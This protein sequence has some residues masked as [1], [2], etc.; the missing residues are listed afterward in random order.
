MSKLTF[1]LVGLPHLQTHSS[2]SH[3][4]YS[5]KVRRFADMMFDRGHQ[6]YLYTSDDND[7]RC[8]EHISCISKEQQAEL[9]TPP[10]VWDWRTPLW[11]TMA[12]N[13]IREIGKR[14]QP[15]DFLCFIAG[16]QK[17]I[18]EAFPDM[19]SVEFGVGYAG[20]FA[21]FV[22]YESYAWMHAVYGSQAGGSV[23]AR[24]GKNFDAVIP[25]AYD[26]DEFPLGK[27]DGGYLLYM[28]RLIHLKGIDIVSAIQKE[29]GLPLV[30]AGEGDKRP[31]VPHEY[32][33]VVGPEK[34]AE[35]MG[36]AIATLYP[37]MYLEPF[38]GVAVETMFTGTPSITSDW[39][40][41]PELIPDQYRARTL[42]EYLDAI[43][44]AKANQTLYR[45]TQL[46][47]YATSRF[48]TAVVGDSY[49]KY[50][51]R[52]ETLRGAGW[53]EL[54]APKADAKVA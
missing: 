9:F 4:A 48:S 15:D 7:A 28:G 24:E 45:R 8:T 43:D 39:G 26:P 16:T 40:A 20:V 42:Q 23:M 46:R 37:T 10:L 32:L 44:T 12:N 27:G 1:H 13:A 5:Q 49:E 50:F 11:Q 29:T 34:R 51:R 21:P 18:A 17:P 36:G 2:V 14:A 22:V 33:G 52:L 54:R 47:N 31:D 19:M 38:G 41:F 53:Y 35:L 3:C 6:V 25:N 30:V